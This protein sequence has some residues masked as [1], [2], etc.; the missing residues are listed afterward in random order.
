MW[1]WAAASRRGSSHEKANTRLQDAFSCFMA[2]AEKRHFIGIVSDGAG[3]ASF[4]GQGA[5][6]V[7]R[8]LSQSI[9]RHFDKADWLPTNEEFYSWTDGIRDQLASIAQRREIALREFASTLVCLIASDEGSMTAHVGDGCAV[10]RERDNDNWTAASWPEHGEYASTTYFM[11]DDTELRLRISRSDKPI[12]A[13]ALF[14]DGIERLA[15]DFALK[16][17]FAR[18]FNVV[19]APVVA[20]NSDGRDPNLS[21]AL[22]DYLGSPSVL[23]RTDDDTTLILAVKQ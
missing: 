13:A 9:R 19:V 5:S 23:A 12:E 14:S 8:A 18:F 4:G 15:L 1:K 20:S 21:A 11:T 17:P 3:S 16:T 7:C 2:G 10:V 22:K 6:L